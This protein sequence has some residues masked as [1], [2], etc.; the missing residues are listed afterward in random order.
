MWDIWREDDNIQK[1][2]TETF[3][4]QVSTG[5]SPSGIENNG[6]IFILGSGSSSSKI[7]QDFFL[8]TQ[9]NN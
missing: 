4:F 8:K 3:F 5:L 1:K 7:V 6:S 2:Y 9:S